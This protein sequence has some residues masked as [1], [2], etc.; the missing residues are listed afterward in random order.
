MDDW[1]V[2]ETE[3]LVAVSS[4]G[5]PHAALPLIVMKIA[6]SVCAPADT[7][8]CWQIAPV[9][10]GWQLQPKAPPKKFWSPPPTI[11]A[12]EGNVMATVSWPVGPEPV[13]VT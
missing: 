11:D 8:A 9:E 6:P 7:W 5:W 10:V 1:A 3:P 12:P 13:S 4:M 2:A